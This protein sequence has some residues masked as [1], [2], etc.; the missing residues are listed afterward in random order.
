M[1]R[2]RAVPCCS[3]VG[4][5][6][7]FGRSVHTVRL[8]WTFLVVS[9]TSQ[10]PHGLPGCRDFDRRLEVVRGQGAP[11][12]RSSCRSAGSSWT[13]GFSCGRIGFTSVSSRTSSSTSR[14]VLRSC[15][16]VQPPGRVVDPV[17]EPGRA[18]CLFVVPIVLDR[19]TRSLTTQILCDAVGTR[20]GT[21]GDSEKE[22]GPDLAGTADRPR[23]SHPPNSCTSS[24]TTARA[25]R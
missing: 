17:Q 4:L 14:S 25:C 24:S 19:R 5:V 21:V 8:F 12:G 9:M 22:C 23:G 1:C 6:F 13:S 18:P 16:Q 20:V 7:L 10:V 2:S 11:G 15:A 3:T